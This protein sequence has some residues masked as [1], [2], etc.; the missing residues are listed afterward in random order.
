MIETL[1]RSIECLE[2]VLKEDAGRLTSQS[3][4]ACYNRWVGE[5]RAYRR[6]LKMLE[7]EEN[8]QITD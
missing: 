6:I 2:E 5:L 8:E 4:I 7:E 3:H 1:K